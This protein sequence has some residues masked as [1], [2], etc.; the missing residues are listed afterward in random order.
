MGKYYPKTCLI[1]LNEFNGQQ[2]VYVNAHPRQK[3]YINPSRRNLTRFIFASYGADIRNERQI[4]G[5]LEW[6]EATWYGKDGDR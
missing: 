2:N 1:D 4:P 6:V 5:T 3:T